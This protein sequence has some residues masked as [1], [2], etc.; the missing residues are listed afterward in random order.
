MKQPHLVIFFSVE[1]E[2]GGEERVKKLENY[3]VFVFCVYSFLFSPFRLLFVFPLIFSFLSPSFL[4]LILSD[5]DI[6]LP[7]FFF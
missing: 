2:E 3:I 1:E 7:F 5:I 4:S 6:E